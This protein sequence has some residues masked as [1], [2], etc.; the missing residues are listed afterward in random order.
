MVAVA[1]VL[2]QVRGAVQAGAEFC[3]L[4]PNYLNMLARP[5]QAARRGTKMTRSGQDEESDQESECWPK[6]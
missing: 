1:E 6:V 2:Q 4:P 3:E 5:F